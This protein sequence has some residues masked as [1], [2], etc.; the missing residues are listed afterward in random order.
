MQA[1]VFILESENNPEVKEQG[2]CLLAN[3]ADGD[4][5]KKLIVD[6]EDMLKKLKTYM[7]HNNTNLQT[8]AVVCIQNLIWKDEEGTLERQAK[9]KEIGV[10]KILHQL[11]GTSDKGLFEKVNLA[12]QQISM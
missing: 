3:I 5:S 7:V 2:L 6:N 12:L 9:L 8:A 4:S 11:L 1:V 10:F